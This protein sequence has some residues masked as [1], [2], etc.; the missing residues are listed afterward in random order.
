MISRGEE[1]KSCGQTVLK[2]LPFG[3]VG[4]TDSEPGTREDRIVGRKKKKKIEQREVKKVVG[5]WWRGKRSEG[6]EGL[7]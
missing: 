5:K 7:A 6:W 4:S 1:R 3:K 2:W